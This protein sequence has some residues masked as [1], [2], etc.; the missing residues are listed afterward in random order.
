MNTKMT[1]IYD[2]LVLPF[3][4]ENGIEDTTQNRLWALEGVY[5]AWNEDGDNS[6]EKTIWKVALIGEMNVLRIKLMFN[7]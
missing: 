7:Q 6:I 4:A 3:M 5:A 2:E 1:K